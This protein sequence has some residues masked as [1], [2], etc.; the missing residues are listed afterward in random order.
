MVIRSL[1]RKLVL[2]IV[3][4]TCALLIATM[5]VSYDTARRRLEDQTRREA[6]KQVQAVASTLD[7]YADR[8]AVLIRGIAARQESIGRE[9]D[10]HT[11]AYLSHL[12]DAISPE[13]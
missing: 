1:S 11:I 8:V 13:E 6:I 2:Y 7:S 4:A 3:T 12:L 10:D 9:P 5:W